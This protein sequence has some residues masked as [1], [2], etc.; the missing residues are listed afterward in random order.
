MLGSFD[1][2]FFQALAAVASATLDA[3]DPFLA[4]A[5]TASGTGNP[6]DLRAARQ[7]LEALPAEQ[8]DR[9]MAETHRRL[10]SDLSAIWDHLP[11]ALPDR[12]RN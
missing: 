8:R 4:L 6:D 11:G 9:L 5:R 1:T 10:A 3:D 7:G 12:L 2:R